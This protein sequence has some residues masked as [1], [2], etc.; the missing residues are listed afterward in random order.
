MIALCFFAE[1]LSSV[2]VFGSFGSSLKLQ[3]R[4]DAPTLLLVI[5]CIFSFRFHWEGGGYHHIY[6]IHLYRYVQLGGVPFLSSQVGD[7]VP[8]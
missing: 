7:K 6:A 3:N 1:P 8:I 4:E 2:F 5:L